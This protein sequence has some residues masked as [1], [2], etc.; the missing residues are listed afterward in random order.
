MGAMSSWIGMHIASGRRLGDID[1]IWQSVRKILTTPIGSRVERR[2]FGSIIPKLI[3]RPINDH[4]RL[5]VM[6][7][8][9]QAVIRWEP[10]IR[11]V[12]ITLAVGGE[13]SALVVD[14][15]ATRRDASGNGQQITL[16]LPLS[17]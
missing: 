6:A 1:H 13:A 12:R 17:G 9:A 16:S 2:E 10:R 4:T 7:A 14:L 15:V 5:Q 11:P 3:D 8:T